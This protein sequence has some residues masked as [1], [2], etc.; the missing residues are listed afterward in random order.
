MGS[1]DFMY[2]V[3]KATGELYIYKD[4]RTFDQKVPNGI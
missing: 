4:V 1:E 3:E 2:V